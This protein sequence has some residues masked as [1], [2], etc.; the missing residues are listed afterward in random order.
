M[1][2]SESIEWLA[3]AHSGNM[4]PKRK[5]DVDA[6]LPFFEIDKD[7]FGRHKVI[8]HNYQSADNAPRMPYVATY[9]SQNVLPFIEGDVRGFYN[10]QLHDSYTYLQDGKDYTN[11][12]TFAKFKNDKGPV[13]LPDTYMMG[14]YNQQLNTIVDPYPWETKLSKVVW[15]GTTTGKRNPLENERIKMCLWSLNKKHLCDFH[16]TN[17][18]QMDLQTVQDSIP[19]FNDITSPPISQTEQMKYRY[20]LVMDGNTCS[21]NMWNYATQSLVLKASSREML[22]YYPCLQDKTHFV[23]VSTENMEKVVRYYES[24]KNESRRITDN[25]NRFVKEMLTPLSAQSYT[26]SLFENIASNKA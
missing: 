25:A 23:D 5:E 15:A 24:N 21:W 16:I 9:I 2:V 6:S 11:V 1:N 4:Y 18:A 13:L 22:W 12:F 14:N 20:Q 17:V 10:I 7:E 8:I 3:K 19:Q 26:M